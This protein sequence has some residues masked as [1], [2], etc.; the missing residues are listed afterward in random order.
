MPAKPKPKPKP[1]RKPTAGVV[2]PAKRSKHA[3]DGEAATAGKKSKT[4]HGEL[5]FNSKIRR[6]AHFSNFFGDVEIN[7]QYGTKFKPS[8]AA[9]RLFD[10]FR[11]CAAREFVKVLQLLQPGKKWT[12]RKLNYW[13]HDGQPI[14]GILAKLAAGA[15]RADKVHKKRRWKAIVEL[16]RQLSPGE[17]DIAPLSPLMPHQNRLA[18]MRQCLKRKY[19]DP[20]FRTLL[21]ATGNLALY[22]Q[23]RGRGDGSYWGFNRDASGIGYGEDA[24]GKMLAVIRMEARD[25]DE[26]STD[27]G[28]VVDLCDAVVDLCDDPCTKFECQATPVHGNS[29]GNGTGWHLPKIYVSVY[30]REAGKA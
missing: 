18:I 15:L 17:P 22:E 7:Y 23:V 24:L 28:D 2:P 4:G 19:A 20:C 21:L 30:K 11:V 27:G 12:P 10:Y 26:N 5:F 9:Q 3:R 13:F 1:K 8:R 6:A 29:N 25:D 14:R 16:G